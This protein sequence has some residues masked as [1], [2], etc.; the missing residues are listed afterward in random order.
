MQ[1]ALGLHWSVRLPQA[2]V[3]V[4]NTSHLELEPHEIVEP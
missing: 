2:W 1:V 4:Q 3:P